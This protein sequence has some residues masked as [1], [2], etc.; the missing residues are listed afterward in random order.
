MKSSIGENFLDSFVKTTRSF[1]KLDEVDDAYE[2]IKTKINTFEAW[3]T[4][5]FV[6]GS[7][8][9]NICN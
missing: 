8:K 6:R 9:I 7:D 1:N 4:M 3:S 2:I 5:V